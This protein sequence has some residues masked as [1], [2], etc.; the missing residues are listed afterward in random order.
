MREGR[1]MA[2][3]VAGNICDDLLCH[4]SLLSHHDSRGESRERGNVCSFPFGFESNI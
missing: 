4:L 1:S 3:F 2:G